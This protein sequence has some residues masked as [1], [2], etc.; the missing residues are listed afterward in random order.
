MPSPDRAERRRAD[1]QQ[2]LTMTRETLSSLIP[3]HLA[4]DSQNIITSIGPEL[5]ALLGP[6]QPIGQ[7]LDVLFSVTAQRSDE[8]AGLP[9]VAQRM[10][11]GF[12]P[13]PRIALRAVAVRLWEPGETVLATALVSRE[14]AGNPA[15]PDQALRRFLASQTALLSAP[16]LPNTSATRELTRSLERLDTLTGLPNRLALSEYLANLASNP[17]AIGDALAMLEVDLSRFQATNDRFGFH[18]GD[19]VLCNCAVI[20][21]SEMRNGDMVARVGGDR[22]ALVLCGQLSPARLSEIAHRLIARLCAPYDFR[23]DNVP[24]RVAMGGVFQP[25]LAALDPQRLIMDCDLALNEARHA[26]DNHFYLF[27]PRLRAQFE[28]MNQ[29]AREIEAGLAA[30]E[31]EPWFQPQVDVAS[32]KIIGFEALA[33]WRHPER[34]VLTPI[35]FLY[36]AGQDSLMDRIDSVM[37]EKSFAALSSWRKHGLATA[38][39]SVNLSLSRLT[40]PDFADRLKWAADQLDLEPSAIGLEIL[41][42]VLLEEDDSLLVDRLKILSAHGFRLE[43]DDFGTGH[44]SISSLRKFRVDRLKIDRSFV[45]GIDGDP[46]LQKITGAIIALAK[47]LGIEPLAEGV[48]TRAEGEMLCTLGCTKFQ[49]FGVARPM[50]ASKI[51]PWVAAFTAQSGDVWTD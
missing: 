49:G 8:R 27:E 10:V 50:P 25:D 9:G 21:R 46:N 11:L 2:L 17:N 48:E 22:F 39:V 24:V 45:A 16:T 38:Q 51:A 32:R 4:Y 43:L 18:I 36:V 5:G 33:R 31:F 40:Q 30:D 29:L 44:S 35:H 12:R 26:G 1:T 14:N 41:E 6:V 3:T 20:L 7:P 37:I 15:E 47:T 19:R 13:D 28:Q 34:G 23:G 42:T